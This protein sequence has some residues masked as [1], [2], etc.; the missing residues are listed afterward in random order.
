MTNEQLTACIKARWQ[1]AVY[2]LQKHSWFIQTTV[3]YDT[4]PFNVYSCSGQSSSIS[5][6]RGA[7]VI[8]FP[9]PTIQDLGKCHE[10][11]QWSLGLGPDRKWIW[12]ILNV[13]ITKPFCVIEIKSNL[14]IVN[15]S[16]TNKSTI[17]RIGYNPQIK[18]K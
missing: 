10:L 17:L 11:P 4:I 12:F 1:I 7:K 14:F 8:P 6:E 3:G 5:S 13:F 15:Y 2:K 18:H 9:H 16:G